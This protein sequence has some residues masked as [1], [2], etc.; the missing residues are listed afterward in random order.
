MRV[1]HGL[2][3]A[4]Q[5]NQRFAVAIGNFDGC[6]L[7]HVA[8]ITRLRQAAKKHQLPSL[9]LTFYPH[10]VEVLNPQK[11]LKRLTT[12]SE[13]LSCFE[14]LGVE[15]VL[16]E[17]FNEKLAQLSPQAF[18]EAYLDKGLKAKSLH[19]GFNFSF[20]K[21]R[22]GSTETLQSFCEK[23]GTELEI[24]PAFQK[25]GERVSSSLIRQLVEWGEVEKAE[26][27]L[28]RPYSMLGQIAHGDGRG[29]KMGFP[30]ANL[31]Y[32]ADKV[33]PKRGVYVTRAIWQKQAFLSVTNVGVRPTYGQE[34]TLHV[35]AHLLNC[36]AKLYDEFI[37]L[38][39][40]RRLRDEK[41]FASEEELVAQI[42]EDVARAK[43]EFPSV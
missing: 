26:Q 6:H 4:T 1:F 12:T 20:G 13:K 15:Y 19:V 37:Q 3:Q 43:K 29:L 17:A 18:F 24:T 39:F 8:L 33:L 25:D 30:T 9:V 10:P 22:S 40:L 42:K 31:R 5:E 41:K 23:T 32:P 11:K 34:E 7:G 38:D 28:G 36:D 14:A 27:Y 35:E 16:V 2:E 21:N